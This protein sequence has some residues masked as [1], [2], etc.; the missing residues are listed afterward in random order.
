MALRK[1]IR[2]LAAC[3][4]AAVLLLAALPVQPTYAQTV[5]KSDIQGIK[6][7]L[8]GIQAQKKAAEK[9]LAAIRGDLSRAREQVELIQ[10]QVVLTEQEINASQAILDGYDAQIADREREIQGLERQE[11]EQY[12]AFY[13]QVRWMEETG[14]HSLLSILFEAGSLSELLDY[15]MLVTD[16][17][18]YSERVI[19][20]LEDTQA[21]LG[22][23][24][25][26]LQED[27]DAQQAAQR[28]LE[29]RREELEGKRAQAQ[30]L[31]G[32]IAASESE[33]A[34]Q[35]KKLADTEAQVSR[36]LEEAEKKYAQQLAALQQQQNNNATVNAGN[37]NWYWPLPGR[38][39]LSSLF[40]WR[41]LYGQNDNHTGTD[42]PAPSGTPIYAAQ[43]GVVT[44]AQQNPNRSSYGY[45]CVIS[46]GGGYATLY[47]HQCRAPVVS[48]GQTVTKG[49]LIGYVGNTGNSFGSHLHFELRVN[50]VRGD[51][52]KLYP[53]MSFT[54]TS[55][56]RTYTIQGG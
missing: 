20:R 8:E 41:V 43:D 31:L 56:G 38:Y 27:R 36:E 30:E 32:Q 29:G 25:A 14:N 17:M 7:E 4:L 13:R 53:G 40:G 22:A 18:R 37:G 33:Y 5:T 6:D 16:V 39:R 21:E 1:G 49:Q 48:E 45:Y 3:M 24:R 12:Q 54:Y 52:L 47:A 42:I 55:N 2:R 51:V 23:A 44:L 10:G 26:A 19:R 46:H 35:A 9:K 15:A 50:G 11:A 34:A 28:E